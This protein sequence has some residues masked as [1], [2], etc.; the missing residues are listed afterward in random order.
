MSVVGKMARKAEVNS[1][2]TRR[3]NLEE[4]TTNEDSIYF[5]LPPAK[6]AAKLLR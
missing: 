5:G 3:D 4:L 2:L 6:A 1:L